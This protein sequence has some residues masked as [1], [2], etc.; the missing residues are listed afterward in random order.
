M[1]VRTNEVVSGSDNAEDRQ[2]KW[3][4]GGNIIV[5]FRRWYGGGRKCN[6]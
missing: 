3:K 1:V 5:C 2:N 6:T 4:K